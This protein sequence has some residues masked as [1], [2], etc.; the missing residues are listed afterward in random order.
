[1]HHRH[2]QAG[3]LIVSAGEPV[4]S[5]I[6]VARGL[7][8][9]SRTSKS[10]R[11]Q[12]L[13]ELGPGEF[14]GEMALFTEVESEGDLV[15]VSETHACVLE[16]TAVQ[17]ELQRAPQLAIP[18]VQEV[19]KRLAEAERTIGDLALLDVGERLAA[20]LLR[21][22]ESIGEPQEDGLSFSLPV[23]WSQMATKLGTTPESL[24]RRLK[25][26]SQ[27]GLVRV[28]GR[29]VLIPDLQALRDILE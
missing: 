4:T 20:E 9:L 24:S 14:F 1:M 23:P 12:V 16:R 3:E 22:A 15:A 2:L 7:L 25:S 13:R 21:L 27:Q 11:E 5:L 29:S 8:R 19:A 28:E 17:E 18:L 10:G 6:V 26:F